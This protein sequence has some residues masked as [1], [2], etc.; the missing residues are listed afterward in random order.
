MSSEY[1]LWKINEEEVFRSRPKIPSTP[2]DPVGNQPGGFKPKPGTFLALFGSHRGPAGPIHKQLMAMEPEARPKAFVDICACAD[3]DKL[4]DLLKD[5]QMREEVV[6]ADL[7]MWVALVGVRRQILRFTPGK[8][9][10][11][12]ASYKVLCQAAAQA[13]R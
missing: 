13:P 1:A 7:S 11:N 12:E 6:G 9:W 5:P 3:R 4:E 8:L 10:A 2:I